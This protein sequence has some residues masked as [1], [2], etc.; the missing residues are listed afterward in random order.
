MLD[1]TLGVTR[2][3]QVPCTDP[4]R[5]ELIKNTE[6][7]R[8]CNVLKMCLNTCTLLFFM[9]NIVVQPWQE[10]HI[11]FFIACVAFLVLQQMEEMAK[12][13]QL[14]NVCIP[15]KAEKCCSQTV[16]NWRSSGGFCVPVNGDGALQIGNQH[17]WLEGLIASMLLMNFDSKTLTML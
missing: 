11:H 7:K 5:P 6:S 9:S 14:E 13:T 1:I 10:K 15:E 4:L 8:G 2:T 17:N 16:V 12:I 3:C